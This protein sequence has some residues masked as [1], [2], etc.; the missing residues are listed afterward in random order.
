[1]RLSLFV[2]TLEAGV[3]D[4]TSVCL[5]V[6]KEE[7]GSVGATGMCSQFFSYMVAEILNAMGGYDQIAFNRAMSNSKMLSSD[8]NAA[9][10]PLYASV[11][12][13]NNC[14]YFGGGRHSTNIQVP[15]EKAAPMMQTLN[16]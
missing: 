1:M 8:V 3:C 16:I 10:D 14:S 5:L 13:K 2:A 11:M 6:D 4:K 7:I 12:E 15:A 9:F